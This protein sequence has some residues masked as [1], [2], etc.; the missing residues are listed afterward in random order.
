MIAVRVAASPS[1]LRDF[2]NRDGDRPDDEAAVEGPV[3]AGLME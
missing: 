1:A 2:W 3:V